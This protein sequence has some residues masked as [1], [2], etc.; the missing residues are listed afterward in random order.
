MAAPADQDVAAAQR[1]LREAVQVGEALQ[2]ELQNI[3]EQLGYLR[4]LTQE[5][6][7][8]RATLEALKPL[9]RGEEVLLPIGGGNFVR[10]SLADADKV[11]SGIGAG[12]SVEGSIEAALA[13][14]DQQLDAARQASQRLQEEGQRVAGELQ[15]IEDRLGQMTG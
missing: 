10:A 8:A 7:R 1:E 5:Y 12:V 9:K 14:V 3:E 11:I 13:R 15:Q 6:Q 2:G 4:A